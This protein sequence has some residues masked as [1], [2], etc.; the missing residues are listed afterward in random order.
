MEATVTQAQLALIARLESE[1]GGFGEKI[2]THSVARLAE[3]AANPGDAAITLTAL[4]PAG[5]VLLGVTSR[6]IA[7][8]TNVGCTS[9]SIGDGTTVGLFGATLPTT[10]AATSGNGNATANWPSPIQAATDVV[11]TA[12]GGNAFGLK[13]RVTAHYFTVSAPTA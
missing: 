6:V 9:M 2:E 10:L 3:F 1:Q 11:I 8:N 5:A 4:I 13:V 12:N 7:P